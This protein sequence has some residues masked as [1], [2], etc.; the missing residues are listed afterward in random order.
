MALTETE[1]GMISRL[2]RKMGDNPTSIVTSEDVGTTVYIDGVEQTAAQD[3]IGKTKQDVDKQIWSDTELLDELNIARTTIFKLDKTSLDELDDV[4]EILVILSAR[5][6]LTMELALDSSRYVRY[7]ALSVIT[8]PQ[9]PSEL[10]NIA[11]YLDRKLENLI[12][13]V[14]SSVGDVIREGIVRIH[15]RHEDL[16]IPTEYQPPQTVPAFTLTEVDNNVEIFIPY[17]F[18]KDYH[19]HFLKKI[20]NSVGTILQ[21]WTVI[22]DKTYT[23]EDVS[24]GETYE[25]ELFV[26]SVNGYYTSVKKSITLS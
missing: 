7:Q 13:E 11:K 12:A 9:S 15:D 20:Y 8:T 21:E 17:T 19:S 10:V 18:I 14:D 5:I 1:I 25:Y 3:D 23:D 6:E 4:E 22:E 2:R 16:M 24:S 26:Q